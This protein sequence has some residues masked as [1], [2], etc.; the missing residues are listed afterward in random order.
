MSLV[1]PARPTNANGNNVGVKRPYQ[2]MINNA[3]HN[4]ATDASYPGRVKNMKLD[5]DLLDDLN[6]DALVN[7]VLPLNGVNT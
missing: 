5:K 2:L 7:A 4:S 1:Q 6:E 3:A